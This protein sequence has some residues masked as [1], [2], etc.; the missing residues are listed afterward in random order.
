[1]KHIIIADDRFEYRFMLECLLKGFDCKISAVENGL[2]A[3]TLARTSSPDLIISDVT[4]P[5]MDGFTLCKE[6][7]NDPALKNIPF[8]IYTA[9][10][11]NAQD[12]KYGLTIGADLYLI[13][14]MDPNEFTAIIKEMLLKYDTVTH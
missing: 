9:D 1:M 11:Y 10:Y 6:W 2:K 4:M 5:V 7:H 3:L 14:P 12:I 13:K 8:I